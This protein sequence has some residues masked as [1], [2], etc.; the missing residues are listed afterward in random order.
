MPKILDVIIDIAHINLD[1]VFAYKLP[2]T[3]GFVAPGY[4]VLVP[5]GRGEKLTEGFV[6]SETEETNLPQDFG[7]GGELKSVARA[8]EDYPALTKEQLEL[9]KWMKE[10]YSCRLIDALRLMIPAQLRGERVREK[11]ARTVRLTLSADALN[12]AQAEL[13]TKNGTSKAPMQTKLLSFLASGILNNAI[14][15][16]NPNASDISADYSENINNAG[17]DKAAQSDAANVSEFLISD[18][19]QLHPGASGALKAMQKK[20]WVE[21]GRQ[22]LRRRPYEALLEQKKKTFALTPSQERTV[23]AIVGA[24]RC[25][26]RSIHDIAND[27]ATMSHNNIDNDDIMLHDVNDR[28]G[29]SSLYRSERNSRKSLDS[30]SENGVKTPNGGAFLLHGVTGSG[31]TE[32]YMRC[33]AAALESGRG[34]IVLVP[35]IALTPQTVGNFR[36]RFGDLV[37]V[38]HSRLTSGERFDEWRRIRAGNVPVVVGAR[39][40]VFAPME[41][42]GLIVIDE[43]HEGTY[44]SEITPRYSALDVAR[45]RCEAH[46]GVLVL[47]SATPSL[48]TYHKMKQGQYILLEMP[49]RIANKPLPSVEIADMRE[50]LARGNRTIFSS[51]LYREMK[52]ELTSGHQLILFINRRGYST[53]IFC[54]GCGFSLKCDACDVSL[55]YHR[56]D[57]TAKCHYCGKE[58]AVPSVCPGCGKPY[59]KHFGTGTQQVEEQVKRYFPGISTLRMDFDTTRGKDSHLQIL[60]DFSQRKAQALIGT[61]M[62]AKGLDFPEVTLVGVIAADASLRIPDYR[63]A[64]RTFQL[65]TQ[66]AGRAGRDR[67]AGKVVVQTYSPNHPSILYAKAHDYKGFYEEEIARRELCELPPFAT[68]IRV[69]LEGESEEPLAQATQACKEEITAALHQ[70]ADGA[71]NDVLYVMASPAPIKLINKRYRY[72]VLIKL[73][74]G[75][76]IKAHIKAAQSYAA[77]RPELRLEL[78][79]QNML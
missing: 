50:E 35:E 32:V 67:F 5:F 7:F 26:V 62:I 54:R 38:L 63:S 71:Q 10:E 28:E 2:E 3:L 6:V 27:N 20:G 19:E 15:Q 77:Q 41:K 18:I 30:A 78:N 72:M 76:N 61:Q 52:A 11:S 25:E 23:A 8:L 51:K 36:A 64:E 60:Q 46:G 9:A 14:K 47:G 22:S 70:A 42:I 73:K 39:S 48:E 66:V 59:L 33:I 44:R 74:N 65:V 17:N 58:Y 29:V 56:T 12:A 24:M 16:T 40:A 55:T 34:A 53:F 69:M 75:E 68:F 21:F 49:E 4:R 1:R 31:K 79:P 37:A 57:E 45:R 43:E 13:T